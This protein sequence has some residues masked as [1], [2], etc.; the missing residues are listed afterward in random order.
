MGKKALDKIPQRDRKTQNQIQGNWLKEA[1]KESKK[2]KK[3]SVIELSKNE[4]VK[5]KPPLFSGSKP[6]GAYR[7][8]PNLK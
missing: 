6:D 3:E 8:I 7:L 5:V 2:L 1:E 4:D